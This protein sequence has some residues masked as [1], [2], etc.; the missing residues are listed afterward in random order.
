MISILH[1]LLIVCTLQWTTIA[2][3]PTKE[4]SANWAVAVTAAPP[5]PPSKDPFYT[6]PLG[7][8]S[9][10]PGAVLR[11]R[12][13]PGLAEGIANCSAAYNILYRTTDSNYK[14]AWAV[15]T[16]LV[17][18][19]APYNYH[20]N[21]TTASPGSALLSYQVSC[22]YPVLAISTYKTNWL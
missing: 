8:E 3:A 4:A 14:P 1:T 6:A 12:S 10:T 5:L 20:S 18:N 2:L 9:A 13:A 21:F 19:S 17:P 16:L 11:V 22:Q 7:Y 15:T